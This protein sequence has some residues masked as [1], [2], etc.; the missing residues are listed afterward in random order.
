MK[1]RNPIAVLLLVFVTFGIY[2][3]VWYVKTKEEMN[4]QGA[5]IPT[6]WLLIVPIANLYWVWKYCEGVQH[7]T[8]GAQSQALA[9]VLLLLLGP[10]GMAVVQ[11][12]FNKLNE[13]PA[14]APAPA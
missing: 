4:S 11:S 1:N 5:S 7:V 12:G 13:S 14:G 6:A 10:I 8:H 3:L 2:A 9:F